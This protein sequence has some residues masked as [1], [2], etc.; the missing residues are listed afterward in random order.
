MNT[1]L[2]QNFKNHSPN[3]ILYSYI[4]Y[5]GLIALTL[6]SNTVLY[7]HTSPIAPHYAV[8]MLQFVFHSVVITPLPQDAHA[9]LLCED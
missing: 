7:R 2:H 5:S 1:T 6:V 4:P 9:V 3:I 8:S